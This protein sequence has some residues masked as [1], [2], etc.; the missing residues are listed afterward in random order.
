MM[1]DDELIAL[2]RNERAS[3]DSLAAMLDQDIALRMSTDYGRYGLEDLDEPRRA[4]Y[5]R[6]FHRIRC[7]QNIWNEDDGIL[8]QQY[9]EKFAS[10]PKDC[11]MRGYWRA[12]KPVPGSLVRTSDT[13]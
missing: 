8:F 11:W 3:F 2:F 7:G 9:V 4:A 6:L 5:V 13:V 1:S 10:D 12:R